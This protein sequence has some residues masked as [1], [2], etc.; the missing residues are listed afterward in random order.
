MKKESVKKD[1]YELYSFLL[2]LFENALTSNR[3]RPKV[4][5]CVFEC[6]FS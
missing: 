1:D 5:N 3:P 6:V 2:E 4:Q